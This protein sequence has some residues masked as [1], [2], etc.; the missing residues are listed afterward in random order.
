M[1]W[2]ITGIHRSG[3]LVSRSQGDIN[4]GSR[5]SPLDISNLGFVW[6][7]RIRPFSGAQPIQL[8]ILAVCSS[9]FYINLDQQNAATTIRHHCLEYPSEL[10]TGESQNSLMRLI[11]ELWEILQV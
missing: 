9:A 3:S 10:C 6:M 1:D 4:L 5:I 11:A 8:R 2:H 7:V